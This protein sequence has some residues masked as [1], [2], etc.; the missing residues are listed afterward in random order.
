MRREIRADY[1]QQLMFPPSVEDWIGEDHPARFIRD[2]VE[3]LD[4]RELGFVVSSSEVGGSYYAPDLLLKAWLYGYMH[5]IRSTRKLERACREHMGLIWLTGG[6][7]PDHNVLS[8][9]LSANREAI[10]QLFKHS[11]RVAVK[12]DMVSMAVHAIDGTK[13]RSNS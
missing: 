4:L 9:F 7:A 2:F 6:N 3:S 10:S 12:C 11:V 1:D 5:G 8:R 13:I